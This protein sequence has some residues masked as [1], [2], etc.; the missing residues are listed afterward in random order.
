[1]NDSKVAVIPE[2]LAELD[3][4]DLDNGSHNSF[5][6]GHCAMEVV[7]WLAG[8]GHTD[9]PSC[10][11][12]VLR[13]YV[14][15][16]NDAWPKAKRQDLKPFLPRM[17]GTADDGKDEQRSYIALDWL[18]RTYTPAWLDLAGLTD[19]AQELRDLRRIVDMVAAEAA[20]PVVR[21]VNQKA[22][23]AWSAAW[24]AAESAA[25]SAAES[26][27]WSAA[28]SAAES[29]ARS[30]ARSAAGSAAESAALSAAWSAARSAARSA[31]WSAAWSAAESAAWSAAWSA[32]ESAALSA[33]EVLK[34]TVDV[35]Q[36][37]A[38]DLLDSMIDPQS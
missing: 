31:A 6:D 26:A 11:S 4:I 20:G 23:A 33:E 5:D 16:I 22:F 9:A 21:R 7:A 24:S 19:E 34:P 15:A 36:A 10:A 14:I 27:A 37:S 3:R 1:M 18:I 30:A 25:W 28:E 29:A 17:V 38:L 13:T 2:R 35:L 8:L 32:A 12:P